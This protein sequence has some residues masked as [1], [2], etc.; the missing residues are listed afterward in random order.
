MTN[1]RI[2]LT[3]TLRK[4][5]NPVKKWE[6]TPNQMIKGG[7][8]NPVRPGD[9]TSQSQGRQRMRLKVK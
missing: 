2:P 8:E 9:K 5:E 1:V 4:G 3:N 6:K 7:E